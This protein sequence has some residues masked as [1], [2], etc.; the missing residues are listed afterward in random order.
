MLCTDTYAHCFWASSGARP[1]CQVA[2]KHHNNIK[3]KFCTGCCFLRV[4]RSMGTVSNQKLGWYVQCVLP[5]SHKI[6]PTLTILDSTPAYYNARWHGLLSSNIKKS[7]ISSSE[8][9][10]TIILL[11]KSLIHRVSKNV[12]RLVWYNC[13]TR[14]RILIFL[15]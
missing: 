2:Y 1:R 15:A 10:G 9:Y 7:K 8:I 13:D 6:M 4:R 12:P 14:E 11:V 5:H 3:T